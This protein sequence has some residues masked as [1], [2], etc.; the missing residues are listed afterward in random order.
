MVLQRV[1]A[2]LGR[3]TERGFYVDVGAHHPDRYSNTSYFYRHGWRG[4]NIDANPMLAPKFAELRPRDIN[5]VAGVG[6]TPS[7][8]EFYVFNEAAVSTFDLELATRYAKEVPEWKI[9]SQEKVEVR[10]LSEIL[11]ECTKPDQHIDFLNVDAEGRDLD[12]L[13][14][15]DWNH[16]RPSIVAVECHGNT[17]ESVA[18][19]PVAKFLAARGYVS[20][21]KT[22]S[23]VI[24]AA[25]EELS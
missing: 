24:F 6:S 19:D 9:I 14:S 18:D 2:A 15:N 4:I 3:M 17:C 21:A 16:Y 25:Q 1:L 7:K 10:P 11:D 12:V 22:F 5:V 13:V 23:T 8:L 20:I